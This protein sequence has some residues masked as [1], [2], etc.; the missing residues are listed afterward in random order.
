M[1]NTLTAIAAVSLCVLLTACGGGVGDG[2]PT[3]TNT[4]TGSTQNQNLQ[5]NGSEASNSGAPIGGASSNTGTTGNGSNSGTTPPSGNSG[6]TTDSGSIAGNSGPGFAYDTTARINTPSDLV[7]DSAGNLY[8]MDLGN[9]VVRKIAAT[10]DVTTLTSSYSSPRSSMAIDSSGNL[11]VID[12][13]S[14]YKIAPSGERTLVMT[15]PATPGSTQA[16]AIAAD[17]KGS[18]YVLARYRNRYWVHK[19]DPANPPQGTFLGN[20][21]GP[22]QSVYSIDTFGEITGIASDANGNLALSISGPETGYTAIRYVPRAAQPVVE[23]SGA[24]RVW[25]V[26]LGLPKMAFDAAGYLWLTNPLYFPAD[27]MYHLQLLRITPEDGTVRLT[28][29]TYPNASPTRQSLSLNGFGLAMGAN[30]TT[31]AAAPDV[32]AVFTIAADGK[33]SLYAGKEGEAGSAD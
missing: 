14:I 9:Q 33:A 7:I 25:R 8:V 19:I 24:V 15:Y 1:T 13:E 27:G 5:S 28:S 18:I 4:E 31:Y 17:G 20:G 10:G 23:P 3:T 30:G 29:V 32:H 2:I 16:V 22:H 26:E 21:T 12:G 11:Y 6:G